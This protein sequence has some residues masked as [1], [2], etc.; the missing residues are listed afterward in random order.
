MSY[1]SRYIETTL[2]KKAPNVSACIFSRVRIDLRLLRPIGWRYDVLSFMWPFE[3]V[4]DPVLSQLDFR[5]GLSSRDDQQQ[6]KSTLGCAPP[7][8]LAPALFSRALLLF[9]VSKLLS[10][11]CR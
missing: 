8:F 9:S 1:E 4:V 11:P 6:A 3:E 5:R 2:A 7:S 10:R